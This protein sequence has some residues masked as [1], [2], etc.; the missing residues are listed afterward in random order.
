MI[1]IKNL[2]LE[3][4]QKEIFSNLNI[5]VARGEKLGVTGGEGSGKSSLLDI[6]AGRLMQT[7]GEVKINGEC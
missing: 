4:A 6:L 3:L 7:A 2:G 5:E 1:Q